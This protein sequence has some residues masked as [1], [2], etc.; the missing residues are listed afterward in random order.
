MLTVQPRE[1]GLDQL[2]P[3]GGHE[4]MRRNRAVRQVVIDL[5]AFGSL[6]KALLMRAL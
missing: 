4:I 2:E 5:P 6:V 1:L 3:L